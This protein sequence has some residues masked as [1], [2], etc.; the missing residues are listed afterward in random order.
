[1]GNNVVIHYVRACGYGCG[2]DASSERGTVCM[3]H[4]RR[5]WLAPLVVVT[6]AVL[7][8]GPAVAGPD[9]VV[10][11]L[12]SLNSYGSDGGR[13][14]LAVV[15]TS[16]NLG[17][18]PANWFSFTNEHP[19]IAQN[20][21][22]L[23]NNRFEQIGMSWV[24]HG[25]AALQNTISECGTCTNLHITTKL[26]RSGHRIASAALRDGLVQRGE[27]VLHPRHADLLETVVL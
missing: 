4:R 24:K 6:I 10:A 12:P 1:M 27:A 13:S 2:R 23:K 26:G 5:S 11:R 22:R 25:F 20:M 15:T 17:D 18:V 9:I 14:A 16:C 19:V 7:A 8:G 3:Q 21:Y